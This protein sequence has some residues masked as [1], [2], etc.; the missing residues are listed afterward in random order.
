[1]VSFVGCLS[2]EAC[3]CMLLWSRASKRVVKATVRRFFFESA[4][5]HIWPRC[6]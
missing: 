2:M 3:L 6:H 1:M 5:L 4:R